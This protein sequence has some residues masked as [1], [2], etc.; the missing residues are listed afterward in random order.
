MATSQ[1]N[2][3]KE[4][5]MPN[6]SMVKKSSAS[7]EERIKKAKESLAEANRE[8]NSMLNRLMPTM[9]KAAREQGRAAQKELDSLMPKE[10][11]MEEVD[12]S[13]VITKK[14]GGM[15]MARGQGKVMKKRPTH[16]Y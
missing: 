11:M 10:K 8:E 9:S 12:P 13:E 4:Y 3:T 5:L 7:N 6:Q 16:L 14:K 2:F 15:V 1:L